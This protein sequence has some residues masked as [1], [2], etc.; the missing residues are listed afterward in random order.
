MTTIGAIFCIGVFCCIV[1]DKHFYLA[2]V[3]DRYVFRFVLDHFFHYLV[4]NVSCLFF[5]VNKRN[6]LTN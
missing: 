5:S 2:M 6:L 3:V 1:M 4:L